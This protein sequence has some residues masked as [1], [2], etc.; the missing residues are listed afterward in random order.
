[1]KNFKIS[2]EEKEVL[3][4]NLKINYKIA[5]GGTPFLIL[6]GW[7]GSSDSWKIV[8]EILKQK[9][10]VICPDLPGFGK[11]APPPRAWSLK[12]Y[13]Q[14]L[15]KFSD[16]L[17]LNDF[18]LLGHSFGGRIAVKFSF[19]YPEKIKALFLCS[20]AGIKE[21]WGLK[22]KAIFLLALIG[23]AIFSPKFFRRFQDKARNIFYRFLRD[24]DYGKAKGVMKETMKKILEEDLLPMLSQVKVKTLIIWGQKDN[25]VPLKHAFLFKEKIKNSR[26]EILPEIRHSPHLEAPEKLAQTITDFFSHK[27]NKSINEN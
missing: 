14:W 25:I 3:I 12:E 18:F 21:K 1:M 15:K 7:G 26:L 11:S 8:I 20:S 23:N 27:F 22:E 9:F 2:M 17:R 16:S 5:G 13:S 10:Q 4:E 19:F 6:H 24:R